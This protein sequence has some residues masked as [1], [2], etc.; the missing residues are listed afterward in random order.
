MSFS[1]LPSI[2]SIP[3]HLEKLGSRIEVVSFDVFD[4]MLLRIISPE[5]VVKS[6]SQRLA[7][8]LVAVGGM[9]PTA[10]QIR[11][12]R[13]D[14]KMTSEKHPVRGESEWLVEEW[15]ASLA[16]D[17][18]LD[19]EQVCRLGLDAEMSAERC[20]NRVVTGAPELLRT[21]SERGYRL[22]ALSDTTL[23][24]KL[25]RE[26]LEGFGIHFETVF[27][28]GTLKRSK[29]KGGGF[30]HVSRR[31]GLP[32]R[33]FLQ[34]G[35]NWKADFVRPTQH[36]WNS[37]W[38]PH[39]RP[40]APVWTWRSRG[41]RGDKRAQLRAIGRALSAD[42]APSTSHPLFRIG[43][44]TIAPVLILLT[45]MQWRL[46]TRHSVSLALFMARDAFTMFDVANRLIRC[47]LGFRPFGTFDCRGV[48]S[49]W[50]IPAICC[51]T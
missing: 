49:V 27:S 40:E 31:L 2:R 26:L 1:V 33:A 15:L 12:H 5:A 22:M 39:R 47:C 28:S 6:A 16:K 38:V 43:H 41:I 46:F 32:A 21:L 24:A 9:V 4:T 36:G 3:A 42:S 23:N 11:Q 44:D 8:K 29:R 45:L 37:V 50:L 35:D 7:N 48:R 14:Y 19:T 10:E 34:V 51:P 17:W 25:L 18:R 13:L 20:H 30:P